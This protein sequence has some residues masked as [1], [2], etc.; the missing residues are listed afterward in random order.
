MH[1]LSGLACGGGEGGLDGEGTVDYSGALVWYNGAWLFTRR[2]SA[3]ATSRAPP[4]TKCGSHPK[5]FGW[6]AV[7]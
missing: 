6:L 1:S 5:T 4:M 7:L 2:A 3:W